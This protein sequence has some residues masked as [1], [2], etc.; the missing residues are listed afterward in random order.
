ML[1]HNLEDIKEIVVMQQSY[2]LVGGAKELINLVALV[3][4]SVRLNEDALRRG[5]AWRSSA[6]WKRCLP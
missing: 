2:A 1:R 4:D 6:K 5:T 3:D